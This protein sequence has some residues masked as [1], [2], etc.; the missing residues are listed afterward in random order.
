M[1][2]ISLGATLLFLICVRSG[3]E[4]QDRAPMTIP[5][6]PSCPTCTISTRHVMSLGTA[7]GPGSIDGLGTVTVDGRGRYWVFSYEAIPKVFAADGRFLQSIGAIGKGPGEFAAAKG[8][9]RT[10]GDSVVILDADNQRATIVGPDLR[11]ARAVR[12]DADLQADAVIVKWPDRVI[13][14][15]MTFTRD[16]MLS[17]LHLYSFDRPVAVALRHFGRDETA[18]QGFPAV[19][20][21]SLAPAKAGAVW[22][23]D[24]AR[25][26][27]TLWNAAGERSRVLDRKP[28]WF[29]PSS[30]MFLGT[31]TTPPKATI[32][33]IREDPQ[34]GLLW[35]FVLTPAGSWRD[36]WPAGTGRDVRAG[37]IAWEKLYDTT[38]EVLDVSARRVVARG[39][40]S[41]PIVAALPDGRAAIYVVTADDTPRFD[42][43][44]IRLV[45][46]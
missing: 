26:R 42:I 14:S 31:P 16:A 9:F 11:A 21:R 17:P 18:A 37:S 6:A 19:T 46:P 22:S 39:S 45:R 8:G 30:D 23:A 29:P 43:V 40:I 1:P 12:L 28:S 25:Y 33:A 35:V 38:V 32:A 20:K 4:A 15:G 36:A 10:P 3:V 7:D 13:A 24:Y 2:R 44:A 41:G 27:V 5:D 34:T